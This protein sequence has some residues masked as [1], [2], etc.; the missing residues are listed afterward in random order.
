[1]AMESLADKRA[2]KNVIELFMAGAKKD[3]ISAQKLLCRL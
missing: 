3:F 1:M 2:T